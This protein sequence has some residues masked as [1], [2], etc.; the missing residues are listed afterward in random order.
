VLV[1]L[2][3]VNTLVT[4]TPTLQVSIP[5]LEF[6]TSRV[7]LAS[8]Q[9]LPNGIHLELLRLPCFACQ[10]L[11]WYRI[12]FS[13][14]DF[15]LH[16]INEGATDTDLFPAISDFIRDRPIL[17]G[18]ARPPFVRVGP[19]KYRPYKSASVSLVLI[20]LWRRKW[21]RDQE[22]K[23]SAWKDQSSKRSKAWV[24]SWQNLLSSQQYN[25]NGSNSTKCKSYVLGL[26]RYLWTYDL[27][28]QLLVWPFLYYPA[29]PL[30]YMARSI[31]HRSSFQCCWARSVV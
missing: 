8:Y 17:I 15:G 9:Y 31:A 30:L 7:T 2:H 27:C 26:L 24:R 13:S 20:F 4:T 3:H 14:V 12:L 28:R 5:L 18:E 19:Q 6:V 25:W 29:P 21:R 22:H 16:F 10:A 11:R 1:F 23:S